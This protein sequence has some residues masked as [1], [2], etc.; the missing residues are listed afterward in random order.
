MGIQGAVIADSN[1]GNTSVD[2]VEF[3]VGLTVPGETV[4]MTA[5][6][7][8]VF[9]ANN[10]STVSRTTWT[11]GTPAANTWE[12]QKCPGV[13]ERGTANTLEGDEIHQV[14]VD[15]SGFDTIATYD[16]FAVE[17]VP[18]AGATIFVKRTM[19]GQLSAKM[20]LK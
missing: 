12:S 14:V 15:L 2:Y 3:L 10:Q 11:G 4:D 18:P 8:N 6:N 19:P 17:I 13:S 7:V 20:D 16:W 9:S 5:L 1:A